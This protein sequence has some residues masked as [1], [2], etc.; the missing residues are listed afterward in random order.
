MGLKN[1]L[2]GLRDRIDKAVEEQDVSAMWV[3]LDQ[4]ST[5]MVRACG[6]GKDLYESVGIQV[7]KKCGSR[8]EELEEEEGSNFE[9]EYCWNCEQA[10]FEEN[11]K[12][13][14]VEKNSVKD[15]VETEQQ[16]YI[17]KWESEKLK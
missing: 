8:L 16:Q 9:G 5:E 13:L 12:N 1:E 11:L 10:M 7:C 15:A 2:L 6:S 14:G 17:L 3:L 4:N